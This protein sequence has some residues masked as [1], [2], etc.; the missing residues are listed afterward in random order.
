MSE[1]VLPAPLL[2]RRLQSLRRQKKKIVFTNGCF[3]LLHL[4]H[5]R[6]LEKAK[7]LGDVLVVGLNT[8]SSV[9]RL[10]GKSRPILPQQ[11][12]AEILAALAAVDFVTFFSEETPD[13][14][15]RLLKPDVLV[16]G[17]DYSP[18]TIVGAETVKQNGGRVVV[19]PLV[20]GKGTTRILEKI[21]RLKNG[22]PRAR[23]R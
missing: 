14:L 17:G 5:V 1:K 20:A 2:R 8:D 10:K 3:D 18:A 12:R 22:V 23:R 21:A 15:I 6:L 11:D 7:K 16:K 19:V 13:K 4:G 9:R